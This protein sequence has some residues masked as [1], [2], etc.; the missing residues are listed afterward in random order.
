MRSEAKVMRNHGARLLALCMFI[1]SCTP[2]TKEHAAVG[3][4]I[5]RAE[6]EKTTALVVVKGGDTLLD[7][8]APGTATD[9]ALVTMSVSKTVVALAVLHLVEQGKI[10]SLD[11]PAATWIAPWHAPDAR[12]A[13]TL[14]QML[15]HT[16]GL[17]EERAETW[18]GETFRARADKTRL[19]GP[20]GARFQYNDNA[21]DLLAL[22]VHGASGS[23]LDD[24]LHATLFGALDVA[25][26][27]WM[28][29]AEGHPR[30][31]GELW[32]RPRDLAKVGELLVARGV[33]R[34]KRVVSER[35]IAQMVAP[36]SLNASYGLGVWLHDGAYV[37][38]GYL[39]QW[40][41]ADPRSHV[42]AVRLRT[43]RTEEFTDAIEHDV[44]K[45]FWKDIVTFP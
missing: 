8:R 31:A 24:Y 9:E 36:S 23:Y 4:L 32:M 45:D 22:V 10:A 40:L 37:G 39:G 13:I 25:G 20:P 44:W 29:D 41:V 11:T 14:R 21:Y 7:Y 27:Y 5:R 16:S 6:A 38:K 30:A 33:Y 18:K 34:G 26:A 43:P 42:V 17:E 3:A 19:L 1:A 12:S 28:K 35:S 15:A 2:A